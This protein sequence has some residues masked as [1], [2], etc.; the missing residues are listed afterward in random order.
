MTGYRFLTPAEEELT[1]AS[2]FYEAAASRL[3]VD[4]LEEVQR[5]VDVLC[6]HPKFGVPVGQSLRRTVLDRFP[7]SIIYAVE[8]NRIVVVAVAHQKRRPDYWR[9]RV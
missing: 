9:S 1:E 2:G 8:E 6:Q 4:F 7:F 3:G 5:V